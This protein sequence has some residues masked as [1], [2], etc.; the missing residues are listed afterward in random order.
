MSVKLA[1]IFPGQGSQSL[2]MLH[3]IA[4]SY[5]QIKSTFD[6]ASHVLQYDLWRLVQD[7]PENQLNMT[8][9][10]QPAILTASVALW[11]VWMSLTNTMP[12]HM[13]GHSLGEYS[14][15]VCAK[16]M[17]FVDAVAIV[18][19]RGELMQQ[20]VPMG[21]GAMAAIIGLEDA[22][23]ELICKQ[24]STENE[25]VMP[26]NYNAPLQVVIAGKSPAIARAIRLAK[27]QGAK[28][29]KLLP[30][31]VPSH[32]SLMAAAAKEFAQT[33]EGI[34]LSVP[35]VPVINNVD[36]SIETAPQAIRKA[37]IRQLYCPVRW[38]SCVTA[39]HTQGIVQ[40]VE[41]GPNQVLAGLNKRIAKTVVTFNIDT[42]TGM[43]QSIHA[44]TA[45]RAVGDEG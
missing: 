25:V 4:Q 15:L 30:V 24:S 13:A 23:V 38:T 27:A 22:V 34:L 6:E 18:A 44:I 14:A 40:F 32:S 29:A 10:T 1:F 12:T 37:L 2:G 8:Q 7:G 36:V 16:A 11:R 5:P 33:L 35:Q 26:A 20:A 41:C 19:K 42:T 39:A 17:S 21:E 28:I 43:H 31:S 3:D 45:N 9:Y